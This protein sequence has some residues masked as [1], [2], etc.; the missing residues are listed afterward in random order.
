MTVLM[1]TFATVGTVL[2]ASSFAH[3]AIHGAKDFRDS[4][5]CTA[6]G[7]ERPHTLIQDFALPRFPRRWPAPPSDLS[8]G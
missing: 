5:V 2:V 4:S 8:A 3:L 7:A 1:Q 6:I